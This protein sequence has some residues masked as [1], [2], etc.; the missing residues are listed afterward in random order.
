MDQSARL[1]GELH[2]GR[3]A[4]VALASCMQSGRLTTGMRTK[5][6][7]SKVVCMRGRCSKCSLAVC[8]LQ[9]GDGPL[10]MP[11]PTKPWPL[12]NFGSTPTAGCCGALALPQKQP[13]TRH[14]AGSMQPGGQICLHAANACRRSE[15]PAVFVARSIADLTP[16]Q[17]SRCS[18]AVQTLQPTTM[19]HRRCNTM[20]MFALIGA[21]HVHDCGQL[22]ALLDSRT[23]QKQRPTPCLPR[24]LWSAPCGVVRGRA[25]HDTRCAIG[26]VK[27][28]A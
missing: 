19:H 22:K 14:E 20:L 24:L 9:A 8:R 18:G 17:S 25:P 6:D 27:R 13:C 5:D 4:F 28:P 15:R 2:A 16:S 11:T 1:S 10:G 3:L 23:R 26:S 21:H 7:T 12:G